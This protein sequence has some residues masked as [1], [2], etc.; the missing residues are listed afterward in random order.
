[1]VCEVIPIRI[2]RALAI[3]LVNLSGAGI[4][5]A[6]SMQFSTHDRTLRWTSSGACD[7]QPKNFT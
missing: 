2:D 4:L 1:M 5:A 3:K 6:L 7:L